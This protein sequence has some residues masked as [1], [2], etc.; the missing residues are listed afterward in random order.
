[1]PSSYHSA[2]SVSLSLLCTHTKT[3]TCTYIRGHIYYSRR[4][5]LKSRRMRNSHASTY[6]RAQEIDQHAL[7]VCPVTKGRTSIKADALRTHPGSGCLPPSPRPP[8]KCRQT[9]HLDQLHTSP[10]PCHSPT[11][12]R[13]PRLHPEPIARSSLSLP[14]A[15]TSELVPLPW[16]RII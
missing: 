5:N 9:V 11:L 10:A 1:M 3:P 7:Q 14:P 4:I 8:Q 15:P 12:H 6:D 16:L 2:L 13:T